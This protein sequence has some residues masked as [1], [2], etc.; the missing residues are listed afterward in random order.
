MRAE[1]F[2]PQLSQIQL[3]SVLAKIPLVNRNQQGL[4]HNGKRVDK[5]RR[6]GYY[7]PVRD[8]KEIS[9]FSCLAGEISEMP[10]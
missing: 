8:F 5:H 3:A 6:G 9:D 2:A 4:L 10:M 1:N 7:P